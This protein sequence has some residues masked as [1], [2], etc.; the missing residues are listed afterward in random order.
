MHTMPGMSIQRILVAHDLSE[1][2]DDALRVAVETA[3][4]Y[5]AGLTIFHVYAIPVLPMPEGYVLQTPATVMEIQRVVH[6]ALLVARHRAEALGAERVDT[7]AVPGA[8]ADEIVRY[9]REHRFDLIVMGTHGRRGVVLMILGSVAES[10][11]RRA[12]CPVMTVHPSVE[13]ASRAVS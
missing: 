5:D 3:R 9:A 12:P 8:A 1:A 7:Q 2:S 4:K 11:I 10:V 6:D 13:A